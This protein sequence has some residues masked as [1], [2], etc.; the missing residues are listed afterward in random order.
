MV[1]YKGKCPHL[2]LR[3]TGKVG[4]NHIAEGL[5]FPLRGFNWLASKQ[6]QNMFE[7]TYILINYIP[8]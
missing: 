7:L 3:E 8:I 4:L 5:E 6:L 2:L 1:R